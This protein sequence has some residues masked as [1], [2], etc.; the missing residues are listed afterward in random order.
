[1]QA[2][3]SFGRLCINYANLHRLGAIRKRILKLLPTLPLSGR[4]GAWGGD[5]EI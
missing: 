4:Q 2:L 3:A 5:A 1:V